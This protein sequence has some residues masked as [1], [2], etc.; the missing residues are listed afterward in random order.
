MA[1]GKVLL[2]FLQVFLLGCDFLGF[3][4]QV[5]AG[6][7]CTLRSGKPLFDLAAAAACRGGNFVRVRCLQ[8]MTASADVSVRTFGMLCVQPPAL[9]HALSCDCKDKP[10]E[11]Q[12]RLYRGCCSI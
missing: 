2:K 4:L 8:L 11:V 7:A 12:L 3:V 5:S 6:L 9:N 1:L 10:L